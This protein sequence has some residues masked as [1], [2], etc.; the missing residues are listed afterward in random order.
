MGEANRRAQ[1][2]PPEWRN[3]FRCGNCVCAMTYRPGRGLKAEWT[4]DVPK[5]RSFSAQMMD[6]YRAGR[7]NLMSEVAAVLGLNIGIVEL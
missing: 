1:G 3:T 5:A 4:P 6:E 7:D 2:A